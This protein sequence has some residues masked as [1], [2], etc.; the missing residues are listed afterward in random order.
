MK[1]CEVSLELRRFEPELRGKILKSNSEAIA[2]VSFV[3]NKSNHVFESPGHKLIGV[4]SYFY[5]ISFV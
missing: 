3:W 1:I 2:C 5:A 4:S